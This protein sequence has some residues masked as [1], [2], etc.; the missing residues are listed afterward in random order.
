M[1][2]AHLLIA[3][4]DALV[5]GVI[6]SLIARLPAVVVGLVVGVTARQAM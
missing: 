3:I 5:R 4:Y 6:S 2:V 1:D